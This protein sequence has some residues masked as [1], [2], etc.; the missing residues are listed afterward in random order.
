MI[1]KIR[2]NIS[3][4]HVGL[5]SQGAMEVPKNFINTAWFEL[6][7]RPGDRGSA[8]IDGHF[9]FI[10]KKPGAFNNLHRLR[11]GDKLS[12]RDE[13]GVVISFVVRESRIYG[14]DEDVPEVFASNDGKAHL[15]LITCQGIWSKSKKNYSE[16]LV[17]FTD[18]VP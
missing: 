5:T 11:K 7:P 16:R 15:N 17:V 2:V 8:V 10:K 4:E 13:K 3:I 12:V 18:L 14:Q 1:P 9:G 6:G